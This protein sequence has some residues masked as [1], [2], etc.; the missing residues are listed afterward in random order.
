MAA[1]SCA[2]GPWVTRG[3][4]RPRA[5][6]LSPT[7]SVVDECVLECTKIVSASRY[8]ERGA[9]SGRF[10]EPPSGEFV[11]SEA[12]VE[13][14]LAPA[15]T[16]ACERLFLGGSYTERIMICNNGECIVEDEHERSSTD[17]AGLQRPVEPQVAGDDDAILRKT[18]KASL[19]DIGEKEIE[20]Y[21]REEKGFV[22]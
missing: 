18:W 9:V 10:Q 7:S 14:E 17:P 8:K 21:H 11:G 1:M 20:S 19:G 5:L 2:A 13:G 22:K 4:T 3:N 6:V 15:P 16:I 12:P